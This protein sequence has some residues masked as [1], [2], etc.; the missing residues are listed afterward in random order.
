MPYLASPI[1][2]IYF[3]TL[4]LKKKRKKKQHLDYTHGL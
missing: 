3:M 2:K 4:I 1:I